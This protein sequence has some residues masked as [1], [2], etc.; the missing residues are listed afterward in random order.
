MDG[1]KLLLTL[2]IVDSPPPPPLA[3]TE[4]L[5][6]L[7][8]HNETVRVR[9]STD[10]S[11]RRS[12]QHVG[13]KREAMR[14]G[15]SCGGRPASCRHRRLAGWLAGSSRTRLATAA[16]VGAH[17]FFRIAQGPNFVID[18]RRKRN[19]VQNLPRLI[20][21]RSALGTVRNSGLHSNQKRVSSGNRTGEHH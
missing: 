15:A 18:G 17:N 2:L 14:L 19:L 6:L 10:G 3:S 11:L 12:Q 16:S 1:S 9:P 21:L 13:Y 7:V 20:V 8:S 4:Q 5:L